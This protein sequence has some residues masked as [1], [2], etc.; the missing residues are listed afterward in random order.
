M[1][2]Q[3][4][5]I[6]L[7]RQT[8]FPFKADSCSSS[9]SARAA[10]VTN[11][12]PA[13]WENYTT[14][15]LE[16]NGLAPIYLAC[17]DCDGLFDCTPQ[18]N[19]TEVVECDSF[20]DWHIGLQFWAVLVPFVLCCIVSEIIL[21]GL[22]ATHAS[23]EIVSEF[24]YRLS[25]LNQ[26][27]A[28][29]AF[30]LIRA[31]FEMGNSETKYDAHD[32]EDSTYGHKLRIVFMLVLYKAK[33]LLLGFIIKQIFKYTTPIEY[34]TWLMGHASIYASVFWDVLIT[35]AIMDNVQRRAQGVT[36]STQLASLPIVPP[37]AGPH[38]TPTDSYTPTVGQASVEIFN[39]IWDELIE[40]PHKAAAKTD[41]K[42]EGQTLDHPTISMRGREEIA[43]AVGVAIAEQ[44]HEKNPLFPS[45]DCH[46]NAVGWIADHYPVAHAVPRL[47][48][49]ACIPRWTCFSGTSS[50]SSGW[51]RRR[52][53]CS[54]ARSTRARS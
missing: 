34:S 24:H 28:Y 5:L 49:E 7:V 36:V 38:I 12:L 42:T 33:I 46:C 47:R 48:R 45:F 39:E 44:V 25:P 41:G 20:V 21:L 2:W 18:L 15:R 1:L 43:R 14:W 13:A 17:H 16:T 27:R 8:S 11:A 10:Q 22:A 35:K 26:E 50:S 37:G 3:V 6:A 19:Q 4:L 31:T 53:S 52:R 9:H 54:P 30:S 23:A 32:K 51:T 29:V 40:A